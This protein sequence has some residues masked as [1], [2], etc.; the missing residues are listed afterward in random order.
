MG[1]IDGGLDT[2][3]CDHDCSDKAKESIDPDIERIKNLGCMNAHKIWE[4]NEHFYQNAELLAQ[5]SE[6]GR[7]FTDHNRDHVFMVAEKTNEASDALKKDTTR[8]HLLPINHVAIRANIE[9]NTLLG[10]ALSHD[11]GMAGNGYALQYKTT[12]GHKEYIK[13][14]SGKYIIQQ[15]DNDNFSEVRAN[16]TLNSAL[17]ILQNRN[18]FNAAGFND[19]QIDKMAVECMAHSKSNSGIMN[20]NNR[21]DW[22]DC[23]DRIGAAVDAYNKDHPSETISF[24]RAAF[25]KDG[26]EL[27]FLA[28][29]TFSLRVGDVSRDS[30]PEAKSQSG[31]I[32]YV[33]RNTLID[34]AGSWPRELDGAKITIG[35]KKDP[36]NHLKSRQVHAGEQNIIG[37]QCYIGT[38]GRFTHRITVANGVSAPKC[39]QESIG[40]HLGELATAKDEQ[41]DV[42]VVFVNSCNPYAEE[43]YEQFRDEAA[44]KYGNVDIHYPWD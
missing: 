16:H 2:H 30:G 36:I 7:A 39:T 32:V 21:A 41:F 26:K 28:A 27:E 33:D 20:L 3:F 4:I 40:D 43:S 13:D 12:R 6:D 11:T 9:K 1:I 37:N 15:E 44:T 18:A 17:N 34:T 5:G 31:E 14:S 35:S 29:E 42:A 19:Q 8:K 22:T 25:E 23:F 38:N 24:N 10:A